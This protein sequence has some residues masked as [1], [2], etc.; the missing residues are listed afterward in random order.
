MSAS[1]PSI[2][3]REIEKNLKPKGK[4]I[5]VRAV[6]QKTRYNSVRKSNQKKQMKPN[7]GVTDKN[8]IPQN[9]K[10]APVW[11]LENSN[12]DTINSY[13]PPIVDQ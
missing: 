2:H 10:L 11:P 9:R 13:S 3:Y 12:Y 6:K 8:P 7:Q 5:P 1:L 4:S